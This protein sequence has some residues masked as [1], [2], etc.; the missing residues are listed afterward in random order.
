[1]KRPSLLA[2]N[3]FYYYRDLEG[4]ERFYRET[5]GL[6]LVRDFG[7]AKMLQTSP[8][9]FITLMDLAY[10]QHAPDEPKTVT[11]AFVSEEVEGWYDYLCGEGVPVRHELKSDRS[12]AHEGFVVLDP[13]GYYLEFERFNPHPENERLLPMLHEVTPLLAGRDGV[14]PITATVIWLYYQDMEQIGR[15]LTE[16]MGL[17]MVVDQGFARIYPA[18]PSGFIGPVCAGEGL[19]PYS[20]KKL[21]TLS[22]LTDQ[23]DEW[24]AHWQRYP[25]FNVQAA[26]MAEVADRVRFIYGTDPEGYLVEFDQFLNMKM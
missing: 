18:S 3:A 26:E 1:M 5:L 9:S 22:L 25:D 20:E 8:S 11:T 17:E 19:H 7:V 14:L 15:F 12:K 10:S 2:T 13:E 4:A 6:T 16:Q 23:L 21:V 24:L